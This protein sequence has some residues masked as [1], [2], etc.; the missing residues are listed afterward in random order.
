MPINAQRITLGIALAKNDKNLYTTIRSSLQSSGD[1][2]DFP[3]FDQ[4]KDKS[5]Q[6][7]EILE[8]SLLFACTVLNTRLAEL[9]INFGRSLKY[10]LGISD[11][12]SSYMLS[13]YDAEALSSMFKLLINKKVV[14]RCYPQRPEKDKTPHQIETRKSLEIEKEIEELVGK[15]TIKE[16]SNVNHEADASNSSKYFEVSDLVPLANL[17]GYSRQKMVEL[18]AALRKE[19]EL[20]NVFQ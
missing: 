19:A 5:K 10:L 11:E 15:S 4:A 16:V 2:Y 9:I 12:L 17:I 13:N 18:L 3:E 1:S 14:L 6:S 8:L 20:R 7:H